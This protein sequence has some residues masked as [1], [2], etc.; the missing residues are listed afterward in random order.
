MIQLKQGKA[1]EPNQ[2]R[3]N[4]R[5]RRMS[6][7]VLR[8]S[9]NIESDIR[10]GWSAYGGQRFD[11]IEELQQEFDIDNTSDIRFDEDRQKYALVH[12]DGL[13]CFVIETD[14]DEVAD[15]DYL[16]QHAILTQAE[17]TVGK[18]TLLRSYGDDWHLLECDDYGKESLD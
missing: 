1:T 14:G 5:E 8:Y 16:R 13:S 15:A 2:M 10:R 7:K 9:L 6:A 4:E 11:T 3:Q 12:H 17:Y 18:V